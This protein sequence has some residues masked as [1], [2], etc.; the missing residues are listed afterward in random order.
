MC[1]GAEPSRGRQRVVTATAAAL[2]T[3]GAGEL[4]MGGALPGAQYSTGFPARSVGRTGTGRLG[5]VHH[6]RPRTVHPPARRAGSPGHAA[7]SRPSAHRLPQTGRTHHPR[8]SHQP[9]AQRHQSR[10]RPAVPLAVARPD[11]AA[12]RQPASIR[13]AGAALLPGQS[14]RVCRARRLEAA[15][16]SRPELSALQ[17]VRHQRPATEH[18]MDGAARRRG[19]QIHP[20]VR[21][22]A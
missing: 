21:V 9:G 4:D 15:A 3:G 17:S 1:A 10:S 11:R 22:G 5:H 7:G 8:H 13:R 16:D 14:V 12:A 6:A 19:T 2:R 18:R 20:H